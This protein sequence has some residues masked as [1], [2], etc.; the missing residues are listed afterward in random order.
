[1]ELEVLVRSRITKWGNR[2]G[3]RIP[4]AIAEALR[5]SGGTPV[6][7]AIDDGQ[8]V[9]RIVPAP[10]SSLDTLLAGVTS[11]NT[12]REMGTGPVVGDESR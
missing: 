7:P 2:L 1:M 4:G 5:V 9:V 12:H 10:A 6:E 8:S 3:L 11:A